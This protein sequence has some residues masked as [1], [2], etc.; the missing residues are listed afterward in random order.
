M[1]AFE[2]AAVESAIQTD[3]DSLSL[4]ASTRHTQKGNRMR[5]ACIKQFVRAK[6]SLMAEVYL[7]ATF[8]RTP[9]RNLYENTRDLVIPVGHITT[10]NRD[11]SVESIRTYPPWPFPFQYAITKPVLIPLSAIMPWNRVIFYR[12]KKNDLD[13]LQAIGDQQARALTVKLSEYREGAKGWLED[14]RR[15]ARKATL[16]GHERPSRYQE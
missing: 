10:F 8:A 16:K 14:I 3:Q 7:L 1:R 5:P 11:I 9:Y 13:I 15:E 2:E 4:R 12:V 6:G